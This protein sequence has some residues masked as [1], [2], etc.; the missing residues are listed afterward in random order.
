L[1][2]T[3]NTLCYPQCFLEDTDIALMAQGHFLMAAE[4][5]A[6][7]FVRVSLSL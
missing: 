2:D 5:M 1:A 6:H 7:E 4:L 3:K